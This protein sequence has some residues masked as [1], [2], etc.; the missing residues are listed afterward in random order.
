MVTIVDIPSNQSFNYP[1]A[2][3]TIDGVIEALTV[4]CKEV[5]HKN[6]RYRDLARAWSTD[7][8]HFIVVATEAN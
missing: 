3:A 6:G 4:F 7:R 2:P 8:N 1:D 5:S